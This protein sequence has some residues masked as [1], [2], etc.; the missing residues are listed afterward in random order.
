MHSV[1]RITA[2]VILISQADFN[3]L[4]ANNMLPEA[5]RTAVF[6][7]VAGEVI[8]V[9]AIAIGAGILVYAAAHYIQANH[10]TVTP[11]PATGPCTLST[12]D[13]IDPPAA[14]G[15]QWPGSVHIY[16]QGVRCASD[17][18]LRC[19]EDVRG[20][21]ARWMVNPESGLSLK[22]FL[23]GVNRGLRFE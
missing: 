12:Q 15:R 4:V 19:R 8:V 11:P 23:F 9:I 18:V 14:P 16:M 17:N 6:I 1:S 2:K 3:T 20:E 7:P 21:R 13:T 5:A 10:I 22:K